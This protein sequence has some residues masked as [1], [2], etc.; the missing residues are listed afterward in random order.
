MGGPDRYIIKLATVFQTGAGQNVLKTEY[1][2]SDPEHLPTRPRQLAPLLGRHTLYCLSGLNAEA[3][4]VRKRS[5]L[6][7]PL[8]DA[9]T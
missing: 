5:N 8:L 1:D 6:L 3:M 4:L 9:P 7:F 2:K